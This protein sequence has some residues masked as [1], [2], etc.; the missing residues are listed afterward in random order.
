MDMSKIRDR[1]RKLLR[2]A[3][4]SNEHE[5]GLA[6]GR[7]VAL[8]ERHALDLALLAQEAGQEF[9]APSMDHEP[10]WRSNGQMPAWKA[11]LAL[12]LARLNGCFVWRHMQ[13]GRGGPQ[14]LCISGTETDVAMVRELFAWAAVQ[15]DRLARL[16]AQGRGR[17]YANNYRHG[18]VIGFGEAII[19]ERE[20]QRDLAKRHADHAK[21]ERA[22]VVLDE[23][24]QRSELVVHQ[25]L[26][27]L[28]NSRAGRHQGH[29]GAR[30][31]GR[32]AGRR[33]YNARNG[34]RLT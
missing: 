30:D 26:R 8:A 32:E 23:R 33:T 16:N 24:T 4:S 21:V 20:A 7:A 15:V 10:L 1:I 11:R 17:V 14:Y 31:A 29:V 13:R 19:A 12:S 3:E 22:L 28:R 27:G 5:A 18:V 6:M 2:L 25:N 34:R 9:E